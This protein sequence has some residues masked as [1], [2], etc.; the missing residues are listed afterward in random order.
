MSVNENTALAFEEEAGARAGDTHCIIMTKEI[1]R[2]F[3][4]SFFSKQRRCIISQSL[5]SSFWQL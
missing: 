4:L 3:F 2:G 5:K 1:V